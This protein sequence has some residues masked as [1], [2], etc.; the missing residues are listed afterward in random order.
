M[1]TV[2]KAYVLPTRLQ[3]EQDAAPTIVPIEA[4]AKKKKH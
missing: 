3:R 4:S 1:Y 2:Y